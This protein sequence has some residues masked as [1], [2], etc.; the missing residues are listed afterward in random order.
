MKSL[1]KLVSILL[2]VAL[3]FTLSAAVFADSTTPHVITVTN[4]DAAEAH[5]YAA[6]QV[7]AGDYDAATNALS[8]V[9]WGSGVDGTALHNALRAEIADFANCETVAEV[10]KV[11]T[12]YGDNS[13][14]LRAFAAVVVQVF[15]TV[16][17]TR[18]PQIGIGAK[19]AQRAKGK[20]QV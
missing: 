15:C 20:I 18:Y 8:N 2:V 12:G 17:P 14:E 10:V 7:F 5:D 19:N 3:V 1:R 13:E 6:Y 9:S 11:L 16:T 4:N